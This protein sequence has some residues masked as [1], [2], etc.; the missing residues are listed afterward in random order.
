MSDNQILGQMADI[1]S[2]RTMAEFIRANEV[3]A[4]GE[5][6]IDSH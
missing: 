2:T 6:C 5:E 4:F 3:M 1:V